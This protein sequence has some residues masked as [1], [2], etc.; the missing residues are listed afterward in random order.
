MKL[1]LADYDE[2]GDEVLEEELDIEDFELGD[3]S[4]AEN[5]DEG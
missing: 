3:L 5:L 1:H 4:T 2:L